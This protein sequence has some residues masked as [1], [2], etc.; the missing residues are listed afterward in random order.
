MFASMG[1]GLTIASV[2]WM[3]QAASMGAMCYMMAV[4]LLLSIIPRLLYS[5]LPVH[6]GLA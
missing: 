3:P 1:V 6:L 4:A 2:A 5:R